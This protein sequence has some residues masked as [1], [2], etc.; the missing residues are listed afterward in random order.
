MQYN[1]LAQNVRNDILDE[2]IQA[3][4]AF[5]PATVSTKVQQARRAKVMFD[6]NKVPSSAAVYA[7]VKELT[8][9]VH[10]A[11]GNVGDAPTHLEVQFTA[12]GDGDYF[13]IHN[14]NGSEDSK[15]REISF[16]YYAHTG[17]FGGGELRIHET[18][19][20]MSLG[21][22]VMDLHPCDNGLIFF[23]SGTW[24]EVLQVHLQGNLWQ[25][26]RFTVNGWMRR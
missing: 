11:F 1:V 5:G 4:Q 8:P 17:L 6:L 18:R 23:T 15:N 19:E 20:D 26:H 21:R 16:V 22:P 9:T 24:H 3:E 12:H 7:L 13:R 14:D 10:K 2:M 25:N